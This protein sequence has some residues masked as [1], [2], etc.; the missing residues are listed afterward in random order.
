MEYCRQVTTLLSPELEQK[1]IRLS[2][3]QY[4]ILQYVRTVP[5]SKYLLGSANFPL[6]KIDLVFFEL[7]PFY[8]R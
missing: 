4:K 3:V 5:T 2:N 8:A 6:E 7:E 1:K